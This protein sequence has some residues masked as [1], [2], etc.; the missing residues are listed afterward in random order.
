MEQGRCLTSAGMPG[1]PAELAQTEVGPL[2]RGIGVL[3]LL[4]RGLCQLR[5]RS[6]SKVALNGIESP[7][8]TASVAS[9]PADGG[10]L[11]ARYRAPTSPVRAGRGLAEVLPLSLF[12]S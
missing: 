8:Q 6:F 10:W 3:S 9:K 12:G 4:S 7:A 5:C 11:A 1:R 2:A